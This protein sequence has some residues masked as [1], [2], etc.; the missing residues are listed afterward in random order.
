MLRRL[1]QEYY[2]AYH[3]DLDAIGRHAITGDE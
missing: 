2:A 3:S 1:K